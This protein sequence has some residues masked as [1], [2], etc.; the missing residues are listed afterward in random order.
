MQVFLNRLRPPLLV[1]TT[2]LGE[3]RSGCIVGFS[4]QC[5]T[6]PLRY[7]VCLS[8]ENHTFAVAHRAEALGVHLLG[9]DQRDLVAIFGEET[10]DQ[11]VD[12]FATVSW[13]RGET[14][15]PVLADCAAWF[16][17]AIAAQIDLGDH[18]GFVL[19]PVVGGPGDHSGVLRFDPDGDYQPGHPLAE[20]IERRRDA[21]DRVDEAELE[22][23]PASDPPAY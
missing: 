2:A 13:R 5:S 6:D 4:A 7:L 21:P 17:G 14:G 8:P 22:S 9:E 16:E 11:R 15:V 12:K 23:F 3:E 20:G 10:S 18:V 19:R 1:V